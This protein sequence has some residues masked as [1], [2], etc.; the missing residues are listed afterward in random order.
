M[1]CFQCRIVENRKCEFNN[2]VPD[3][4]GLAKIKTHD[5]SSSHKISA[6]KFAAMTRIAED[7]GKDIAE[8]LA[9]A[10]EEEQSLREKNRLLNRSGMVVIFSCV[11]LLATQGLAFR[12]HDESSESTNRG[13]FHALLEHTFGIINDRRSDWYRN[14]L[15]RNTY[16]SAPTQNVMINIWPIR[17]VP[18]FLLSLTMA[19][20]IAYSRHVWM[21]RPNRP[22]KIRCPSIF[23]T[24]R[25][26][27]HWWSAILQ[28]YRSH[29]LN[30][31]RC[32]IRV[33]TY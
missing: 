24:A 18:P 4:N 5:S 19:I 27:A 30:P 22:R 8:I 13:N 9:T 28:S 7:P 1:F 29:R 15:E 21:K 11:V 33:L 32:W 17:F 12:G 31:K 25:R 14:L 10:N 6:S 3:K 26:M 16:S 2:V 23:D 20:L